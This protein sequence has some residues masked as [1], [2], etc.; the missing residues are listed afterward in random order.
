MSSTPPT[1]SAGTVV[2][3]I[4]ARYG[5]ERF[6][7]KPLALIAGVPMVVRVLRNVTSAA[8][9]D[10]VLVATDDVRIASVVRDAGGEAVMT[11][12]DL[13]SGSDRVWAAVAGTDAAIIVNVQGDEPLLGGDVVDA[14]VARLQL[15]DTADIATAVV[16]VP[17]ASA[18]SP[19]AVTVAMDDSGASLYFSRSVIPSGADPVARHIGIYAY[20]RAA[21][22]RFVGAAPTSL[23]RTEKLEQLRAL[24]LGLKIGAVVVETH[25]QAIDRPGDVAAVERLL[26]TP[27]GATA[28]PL[29][30]IRLVVLDVDGVLTEGR[31]SYLG[32]EHQLLEFDVKDGFGI[33]ALARAGIAVALLS[34]RDS[35]AL[36]RRAAELGVAHVRADVADKA[37]GLRQVAEDV[38]VSLDQLCY[39][40]DDEPDV[41]AMRLAGLAAAPAD[42]APAALAAA[43]LVLAH[44]GGRGAVRELADL[45]LGD[46]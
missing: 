5:S 13:P 39:M 34:A 4:P 3:V 16:R 27:V 12:P 2:A 6:P 33:V 31:I 44:G 20:R 43:S 35:P 23:E 32:D 11:S 36:R 18:M 1:D 37:D 42:A 24:S 25:I 46:H 41:A 45:L 26:V 21:L 9:V 17:R 28:S 38:G 7:A 15:D 40:G 19:D 29:S 8:L 10:R 22:E 30:A 14:V